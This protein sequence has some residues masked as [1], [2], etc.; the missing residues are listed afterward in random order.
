MFRV[1]WAL[2]I[3]RLRQVE[4]VIGLSIVGRPL[5]SAY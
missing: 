3:E 1:V 4:L 5:G 2:P